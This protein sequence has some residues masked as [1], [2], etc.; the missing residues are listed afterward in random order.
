[1]SVK[2]KNGNAGEVRT[3][4]EDIRSINSA[5]DLYAQRRNTGIGTQLFL[6]EPKPVMSPK[7]ASVPRRANDQEPLSPRRAAN[8]ING[9]V[10]GGSTQLPQISP[11]NKEVF[12]RLFEN[13]I[14]SHR[15]KPGLSELSEL[16]N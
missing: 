8:T 1:M 15:R 13:K 7:K 5:L 12:M 14:P 10:N 9:P 16:D 3:R 2:K 4:N 11:R 6:T